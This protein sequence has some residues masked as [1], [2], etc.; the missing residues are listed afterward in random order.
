MVSLHWTY[1]IVSMTIMH[2]GFLGEVCHFGKM[3]W[4]SWAYPTLPCFFQLHVMWS[5]HFIFISCF[6][7]LPFWWRKPPPALLAVETMQSVTPGGTVFH[8]HLFTARKVHQGLCP[9]EWYISYL[10]DCRLSFSSKITPLKPETKIT[11]LSYF[12]LTLKHGWPQEIHF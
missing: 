2:D 8:M 4:G 5:L 1:R 6:L 7:W 12:R 10:L 3:G 11:K 9:T